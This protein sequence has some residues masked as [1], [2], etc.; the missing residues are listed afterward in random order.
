MS[1]YV[2]A[3]MVLSVEGLADQDGNAVTGATVNAT[4]LESD[5]STEVTGV[6]W[7]VTLGDDGGGDY[8]GVIDDA[9][10]ITVGELYWIRIDI[11]GGGADDQRWQREV[12]QRR[13]FND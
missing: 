5:A 6:T 11:S 9:V 10:E 4:V 12:A 2:G 13:G 1:L 7:P 8:S 3:D